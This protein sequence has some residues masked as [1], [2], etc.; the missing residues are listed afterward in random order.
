MMNLLRNGNKLFTLIGFHLARMDFLALKALN[1]SA[2]VK[3]HFRDLDWEKY[4]AIYMMAIRKFIL[5]QEF[6]STAR[7][8]LSRIIQNWIIAVNLWNAIVNEFS[9]TVQKKMFNTLKIKITERNIKKDPIFV[10]MPTHVDFH[11]K[12]Q[13]EILLLH[14][15]LF[16]MSIINLKLNR[17]YG[18]DVKLPLAPELT[19]FVMYLYFAH[20]LLLHESLLQTIRK[21]FPEQIYQLIKSYL[22]SRSMSRQLGE[23]YS[24]CEDD[25]KM[26]NKVFLL[27]DIYRSK[28]VELNCD[29]V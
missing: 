20:I 5:K 1:D 21:Q 13:G 4:I 11:L 12:V 17:S 7:R 24:T 3:L 27:A 28:G 2:M 23:G 8:R 19:S 6:K 26:L 14:R 9:C 29:A 16:S 25:T 18:K 22:N 10:R 15:I